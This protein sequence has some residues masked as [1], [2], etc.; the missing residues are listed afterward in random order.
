[1]AECLRVL[2]VAVT[3]TLHLSKPYQHWVPLGPFFIEQADE[4]LSTLHALP[5]LED[6]SQEA[7]TNQLT[8]ISMALIKLL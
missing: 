5:F 3:P 2:T 6:L 4:Q 8:N 7:L 1:M